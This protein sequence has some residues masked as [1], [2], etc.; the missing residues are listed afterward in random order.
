MILNDSQWMLGNEGGERGCEVANEEK[1][2]GSCVKSNKWYE[3][4]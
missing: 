4:G 1:L 3:L 2:S